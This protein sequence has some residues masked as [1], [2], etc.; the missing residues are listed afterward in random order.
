MRQANSW[1]ALMCVCFWQAQM[2]VMMLPSFLFPHERE[3]RGVLFFKLRSCLK[4]VL[5]LCVEVPVASSLKV[6]R[7]A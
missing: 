1:R 2:S 5:Y 3:T 6:V 4:S 7:S